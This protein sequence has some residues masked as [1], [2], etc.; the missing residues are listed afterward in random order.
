[1]P[2]SREF[3]D[4]K[5][6]ALQV[7]AERLIARFCR[8]ERADMRRALVV[9][10]GRRAGRRLLEIL[11]EQCETVGLVLS[12]P[13]IMTEGSFPEELYVPKR[14]FANTLTQQLAWAKALQET[15]AAIRKK[16]LPHPPAKQDTQRW[17][18]L[19]DALRKQHLDLAADG[20]SF[21]D[22]IAAGGEL[23]GFD[24]GPRWEALAKVQR[25]YHDLLDAEKLWDKQSARLIAIKNHELATD[26]LLFLI[27]TVDLNRALR[28]MLQQVEQQVTAFIAAPES[29]REAFDEFGCLQVDFWNDRVLPLTDERI[30]SADGPADQAVQAARQLA[31]LEGKF[32]ADEVTIGVADETLVPQ[33][34]RQLNDFGIATRWVVGRKL[35]ETGP[36]RF[37]ASAAEFVR[38]RRYESLAALIRHADVFDYLRQR[39]PLAEGQVD[40]LTACDTYFQHHLPRFVAEDWLGDS[41]AHGVPKLILEELEKLLRPLTGP[42]QPLERWC[43]K[44]REILAAMYGNRPLFTQVPTDRELL[45]VGRLLEGAISALEEVPVEM[46]PKVAVGDALQLILDP[47]E[48]QTIPPS[49]DPEAIEMLGWLELALDDAPALI[50]LSFNE[51]FV[52]QSQHADAFLPN[53]LREHLGL[54]DNRRRYARDAYFVEAILASRPNTAWVVGRRDHDGNPL[55]PSRL[56][57]ATDES[58]AIARSLRFFKSSKTVP[59][60]R[61]LLTEVPAPLRSAFDVPQPNSEDQRRQFDSVSVT[62]FKAYLSCR[63]RFYLQYVLQLN[64]IDDAVKELDASEFGSLIHEVLQHFG[65]ETELTA[66][67]EST[68]IAEY[69]DD[70]LAE[71]VNERYGP[72]RR[73]VVS[74][75]AEQAR[76]RLRKFADWQAG[77]AAEGWQ[78]AFTEDS[79]QQLKAPFAVDDRSIMLRGR[80]DRIDWHPERNQWQILD[81][82]TGDNATDPMKAHR[83]RDGVWL[84]LQLPLY[85]HLAASLDVGGRRIDPTTDQ[86][87]LGYVALPKDSGQAGLRLAKWTGDELLSADETA[88]SVIRGIWN[89]EFW[90]RTDPAPQYSEVFAAICQDKLLDRLREFASS[91]EAEFASESEAAP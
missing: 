50:L 34:Q 16:I 85:R 73:G 86:I 53:R 90:P 13:K 87:E 61:A 18:A 80:I 40:L 21:A 39:I 49:A 48:D 77:R 6:P 4:W 59:A 28:Q 52:P 44:V 30:F 66:C 11:V 57:F 65:S 56:L 9:V 54:F 68:L 91:E 69:L 32:R 37:L 15:P 29:M 83:T 26:R 24:E 3:L 27:G 22:V 1:M 71:L 5:R 25:K 45:D 75:Q 7:A 58:T 17:L 72:K 81:Y 12:P 47:L 64:T 63:Y 88:R 42:P 41:G 82:K 67:A 19:G 46:Q 70:R 51:G 62:Q 38:E 76:A 79:V 31:A 10:P 36:W 60:R 2:L 8:G 23:S 89:S 55:A 78:I 20:Y 43:G 14:P 74:L 84:D 35:T 33:V